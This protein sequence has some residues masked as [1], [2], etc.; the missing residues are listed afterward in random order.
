MNRTA[1]AVAPAAAGEVNR[2]NAR[3]SN[4]RGEIKSLGSNDASMLDTLAYAVAAESAALLGPSKVDMAPLKTGELSIL[5]LRHG[6]CDRDSVTGCHWLSRHERKRVVQRAGGA[7]LS[8]VGCGTAAF[9]GTGGHVIGE[10]C[11]HRR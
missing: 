2:P 8:A 7:T 6:R 5:G 10:D 3:N 11:A 1:N 9:E 4:P